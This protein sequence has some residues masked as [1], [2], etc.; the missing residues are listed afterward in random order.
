MIFRKFKVGSR[1]INDQLF[2]IKISLHKLRFT[3]NFICKTIKKKIAGKF[4]WNCL[5]FKGYE[6]FYVT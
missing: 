2:M 6:I 1:G 5:Q 4:A 3:L